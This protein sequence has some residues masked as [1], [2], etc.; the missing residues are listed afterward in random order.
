[1]HFDK[2]LNIITGETGAGKSI[3]IGALGLCLGDRADTKVLYNQNE[4]CVVEATF[5]SFAKHKNIFQELDIDFQDQTVLRREITPAGKSRAFINDTPTTL[6]TLKQVADLLVNLSSQHE[7]NQFNQAA[8]QL[9]L[10]DTLAQNQKLLSA[11]KSV[12]ESYKNNKTD[13]KNLQEETDKLQ[14]EYDFYQFQLIELIEAD[15][16]NDNLH[17]LEE[18][19]NVLNNAGE[20]KTNLFKTAGLLENNDFS[21]LSI[22]REA[23]NSLQSIEKYN[24]EYKELSNRLNS[25]LLELEDIKQEAENLAENTEI[26]EERLQIITAKVNNINRLLKKHHAAN[27]EELLALKQ[28]L[29]T[30]TLSVSENHKKINVLQQTISAQENELKTK[31]KE[32]SEKRN[33]SAQNATKHIENTLAKVG[34]PNAVFKINIKQTETFTHTGTDQAQFLFNANKG[35]EPQILNKI[36]SG[37]ELSR[38][39]LSIH[40]LLAKSSDLPTL[41]FDEIDTGISG[42]TAAKVSEIF[43]EISQ[44][45][46]LIAITHLPQ[47]A[48][49]AEKH[50]FIYKTHDEAKTE[51]KIAALN[52]EQH[53]RAI[54]R[55]LSGEKITDESINNAKTLIGVL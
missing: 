40:Y 1:M 17:Q 36:A 33:A 9:E 35:F 29:E 3:L 26:D 23:L 4:K 39:L 46:Q 55:M 41:I 43:K 27:L 37:G 28:D 54:A 32:L 7:A 15:F 31:A 14:K 11:Y 8:F 6:E 21:V 34:M 42:E 49:K 48:A 13:L 5:L 25:C 50:F 45:H 52:A 10:L 12:F 20:I 38:V 47:I 16:E 51:T 24:E 19:L 53:I 2:G 44:K 30:K 22:V 18:E